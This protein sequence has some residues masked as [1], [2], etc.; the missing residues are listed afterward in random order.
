MALV[1]LI[2][3]MAFRFLRRS[4]SPQRA[5]RTND[6]YVPSRHTFN[7]GPAAEI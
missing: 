6:G 7:Q 5:A 3:M 2:S 4:H 1:L